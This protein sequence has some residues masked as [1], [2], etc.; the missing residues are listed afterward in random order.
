MRDMN[1]EMFRGTIRASLTLNK[2]AYVGDKS[3]HHKQSDCIESAVRDTIDGFLSYT[4]WR[5]WGNRHTHVDA[6]DLHDKYMMA[7]FMRSQCS[8]QVD[9][10]LEYEL[11]DYHKALWW[12]RMACIVREAESCYVWQDGWSWGD[13]MDTPQVALYK[14]DANEP[15]PWCI[16]TRIK[17]SSIFDKNKSKEYKIGTISDVE[18]DMSLSDLHQ[19]YRTYIKR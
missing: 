11:L 5:P 18:D 19:M 14:H 2:D 7:A 13:Y 4:G 16:H 8:F 9:K 10:T 6:F 17:I 3:N 15:T 1:I 12:I